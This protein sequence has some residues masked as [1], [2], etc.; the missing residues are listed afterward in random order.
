MNINDSDE[1]Y[2]II[3]P[4]ETDNNRYIGFIDITSNIS[5][6][7]VKTF[8]SKYNIKLLKTKSKHNKSKHELFSDIL[9]YE[10]KHKIREGLFFKTHGIKNF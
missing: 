10:N 2:F 7:I 4:Y 3:I 6:D 9:T 1:D 8:C 5:L